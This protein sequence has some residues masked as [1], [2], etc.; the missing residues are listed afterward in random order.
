MDDNVEQTIR[1]GGKDKTLV[2][3]RITYNRDVG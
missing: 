3:K 2:A 1:L